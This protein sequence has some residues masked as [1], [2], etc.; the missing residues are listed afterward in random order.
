[1]HSAPPTAGQPWMPPTPL[2]PP[3]PMGQPGGFRPPTPSIVSEQL[4]LALRGKP[5]PRLVLLTDPDSARATSFRVLRD[6]LLA[7]RLPR[8]LAV[9]SAM[10]KDG[11]TTCAVNLALSLSEGARVLLLDGNLF[12][13]SLATIF[14]IDETTPPSQ[15]NGPWCAPYRI[16]EL[17]ATL[18]VATIALPPGATPPRFEKRWFEPLL[19]SLRR[20]PYDFII[21]DTPALPR[22]PTVS[23]LVAMADGTL[24]AVRS[25]ATTARAL[26]RAVEQIP[27]GKALGAALI[28]TK[29]TS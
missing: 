26:R 2:T 16:A 14:G 9:S 20:T 27:E 8:V 4:R 21:V 24:L 17:S 28:D 5:D 25:G 23:Q 19:A 7:K 6:N 18:H 15:M 11:K 29:P 22:S 10:A 12:E 13:P 3:T 1:M